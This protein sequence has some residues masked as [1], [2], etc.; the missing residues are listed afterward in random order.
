MTALSETLFESEM[1]GHVS[2]AFTGSTGEKQGL[3]ELAE[4]GTIFL[5]EIGDMPFPLQVKL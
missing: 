4:G 2:G 1:F 5:D 3:F